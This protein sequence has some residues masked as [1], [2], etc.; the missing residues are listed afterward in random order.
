VSSTTK[1]ERLAAILAVLVIAIIAIGEIAAYS[2]VVDFKSNAE[3]DGHWSVSSSGSFTYDALL[4]NSGTSF[5]GPEKFMIYYDEDYG[6]K[7]NNPLIEVGARA[8]DQNYYKIQ[9]LNNLEYLGVKNVKVVKADELATALSD[10][11]YAHYG[12]IVISGALPSTV[13]N[14]TAS[15]LILS[16]IS[17]GG[18]LYWAGNQLGKY[19]GN[20]DSTVTE[21]SG[22]QNLF[23]GADCINQAEQSA[24][25]RGGIAYSDITDNN[26]RHSLCLKNNNNLYGINV[27]M[28]SAGTYLAAGYTQDG[29]ASIAFVQHGAGQICVM[30]GDY[31]NYQ[32][33]DLA[34]VIASGLCWSTTVSEWNHGTISKNTIN[35]TFDVSSP[36]HKTVF[37]MVGGDFASYGRSYSI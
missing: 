11:T 28:L 18:S 4:L 30:A 2:P 14:G 21:A 25:R 16:W 15:S 10:A 22:Y 3:S 20:A 17:N 23:F 6:S 12:L 31:S 13:Y 24:N 35:G 26:L 29:Y 33:M 8:L 5:Q 7:V 9:L 19:I 37:I 32:R 1:S 34:T 27:S 36:G